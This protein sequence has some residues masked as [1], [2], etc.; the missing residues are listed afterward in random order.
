MFCHPCAEKEIRDSSKKYAEKDVAPL[1]DPTVCALCGTDF[2]ERELASLGNLP[3]CDPC[4]GKLRHRPI[5]AWL[6]LAFLVLLELLA[7][8]IGRAFPYFRAEAALVRA[9][10]LME[11]KEYARASPELGRVLET[12]PESRKALLLKIKADL[13]SDDVA[14]A[15]KGVEKARSKKFEGGLIEEV[16]NLLDRVNKAYG[17]VAK[18]QELAKQD[19]EEEALAH[20]ENARRLFPE[21][22]LIR[23]LHLQVK[24]AVHFERKEY[25]AFLAAAEE[26]AGLAPELPRVQASLASA[27]AA[28]YA[29]TGD[30][31]WRKKAQE[32][33]EEARALCKTD[34]DRKDFEE[35]RERIEYRLSSKEI[36]DKKEYDRRF[37]GKP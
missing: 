19:K 11:R 35:Y 18:V 14:S 25:N 13:L 8:S 24:G 26:A 2:G 15:M 34:Q 7:V 1:V 33:L 3:A 31:V 10:R 37:R 12:A 6:F 29:R 9:E 23:L 16:N 20:A 32:R 5:P 21:S 27:L 30:E 22:R 4:A 36:I 17:E 28:Q